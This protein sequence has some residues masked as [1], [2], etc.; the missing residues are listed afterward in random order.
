MD[1]KFLQTILTGCSWCTT[2]IGI[3]HIEKPCGDMTTP[4]LLTHGIC[5]DCSDR[6][7][8][9]LEESED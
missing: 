8:K 9:E 1:R 3:D 7:M 5:E 2:V 4:V 6:M